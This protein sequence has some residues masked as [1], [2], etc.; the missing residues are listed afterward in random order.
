MLG[1]LPDGD[2]GI[3]IFRNCK[4]TIRTIPE[5]IYDAHRPEDV[6]TTQEDHAYDAL[7]YLLTDIQEKKPAQKQ[8][9][10]PFMQLKG[11]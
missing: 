10:N 8:Q 9:A 2:P 3:V 11:W 4:N 1:N 5:L 7:R 6:D